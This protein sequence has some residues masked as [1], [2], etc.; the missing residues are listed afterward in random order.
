[1][2]FLI[3]YIFT[4][5]VIIFLFSC[6]PATYRFTP[7][8]NNEVEL[9]Y[10]DGNEVAKSTKDN[11][12]VSVFASR[13]DSKE[14]VLFVEYKN[15]SNK[16]INAIPEQIKVTGY[17]PEN[18]TNILKTYSSKEYIRKLQKK[19][20][21]AMALQGLGQAMESYNAGSSTSTTTTTGSVYGDL[22]LYGSS[23]STTTTYDYGKQAE[24]NARNRA[25]LEKTAAE[26]EEI[27]N[28]TEQGLLK[29]NTLAPN[30]FV[31]GGVMIKL[32]GNY[33]KKYEVSIPFG[34]ETHRI[35]F[36]SQ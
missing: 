20:A 18:E 8:V 30:T 32:K 35:V 25:E 12:S 28:A 33:N 2:K 21:W 14:L 11:S 7:Q 15:L 23:T 36:I 29:A 26:F 13:T 17:N 24:A 31:S 4:C 27:Q 10:L 6:A 19:Q 9:F 34:T 16:N 1:M 5:T 3:K 22:N